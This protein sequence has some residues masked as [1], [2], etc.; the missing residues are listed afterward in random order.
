MF[1]LQADLDIRDYGKKCSKLEF[2]FD[3]TNEQL[4][5]VSAAL[6]E[7]EKS[8]EELEAD[9]SALA[10]RIML[11]EEESKKAEQSLA[12][13][14]IKLALSSK[15]ADGILKKVK[16][17]ES[18]CL[19][20]EVT[21]EELDKMLKQTIKMAGDNENKLDELTRKLGVQE[22][23]LKIAIDR[24]ELAERKLNTIEEELQTVGEKLSK[25][26]VQ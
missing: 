12:D 17:V 6:E 16:S 5:K 9:I 23:E 19:N 2:D 1:V 26:L 22:E 8:L 20:N 24:A 18:K 14:V 7:K 4:V 21:I 11:M 3:E 15:D 25:Y 10:R 13:T